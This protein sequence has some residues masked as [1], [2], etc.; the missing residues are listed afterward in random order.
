MN[1]KFICLPWFQKYIIEKATIDK[2]E[3]SIIHMSSLW[4]EVSRIFQIS[5]K[6]KNKTVIC[7][8]KK[9]LH[10]VI[11]FHENCILESKVCTGIGS[12]KY[13]KKLLESIILEKIGL[14]LFL[15]KAIN[16]CSIF[17]HLISNQNKNPKL[18]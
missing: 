9:N 17:L 15:Q 5:Q 4:W 18:F 6:S 3:T 7:N 12:C 11:D 8:A 14:I 10:F 13:T 16:M 1:I 2:I